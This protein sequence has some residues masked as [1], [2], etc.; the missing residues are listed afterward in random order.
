MGR[1]SARLWS[2][3]PILIRHARSAA[4][5]QSRASRRSALDCFA[6]LAMTDER[7]AMTIAAISGLIYPARCS[8]PAC[9]KASTYAGFMTHDEAMA[10]VADAEIGWF[11]MNDQQAMAET[12]RAATKLKWLNSIYRRL[13]FP[14]DGCA[15]RTR[16]YPSP[17]GPAINA[18]TIAEYVVMGQ[19]STSPRATATWCA[20]RIGMNGLLDF[21]RQAR[22]GGVEGAPAG[23]Y[24]AIGRLIE[25]RLK[26]FDVEVS[27]VR[28]TPP[29]FRRRQHPRPGSVARAAWRIF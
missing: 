9:P 25:P 12:L 28:R 5:K 23:F 8:N 29:D 13:G 1:R 21:A 6:A 7:E 10:A 14:A 24:G 16:D 26:A 3:R 19:C 2:G 18:I 27:V 11:D 22:I 17:T 20:R 4:T 15:D